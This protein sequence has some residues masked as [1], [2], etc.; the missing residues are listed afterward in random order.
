[1]EEKAKSKVLIYIIVVLVAIIVLLSIGGIYLYNELSKQENDN[2]LQNGVNQPEKQVD[3]E[4][5]IIK[6]KEAKQ[7]ILVNGKV[8][9]VK[10]TITDIKQIEDWDSYMV[11]IKVEIDGKETE[12]IEGLSALLVENKNLLN[13][14]NVFGNITTIKGEDNKDYIII[15][16]PDVADY[17]YILNENG[18]II[19]NFQNNFFDGVKFEKDNIEEEYESYIQVKDNCIIEYED[20]RYTDY[21][22]FD[23]GVVLKKWKITIKDNNLIRELLDTYTEDE[24]ETKR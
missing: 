23:N 12:K 19:A 7:N 17:Y 9:E 4:I 21:K 1:M 5:Q 2:Q 16:F 20:G 6:D 10:A 15:V 13:A 3:K 8:V 11:D 14:S 18:K 24:I 22:G